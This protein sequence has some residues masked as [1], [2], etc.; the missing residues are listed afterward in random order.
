MVI[1]TL[2][3]NLFLITCTHVVTPELDFSLSSSLPITEN[4]FSPH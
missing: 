3:A 1:I 4:R 2:T